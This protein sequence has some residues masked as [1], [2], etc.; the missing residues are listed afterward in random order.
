MIS[1]LNSIYLNLYDLYCI[2]RTNVLGG[3][4]PGF[5]VTAPWA[6]NCF[7]DGNENKVDISIVGTN[8]KFFLINAHGVLRRMGAATEIPGM[9]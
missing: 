7:L 3:I 1:Q 2:P 8:G 4:L 5:S 9:V 6:F